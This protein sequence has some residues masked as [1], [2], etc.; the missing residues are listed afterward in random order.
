MMIV[1]IHGME[2]TNYSTT[3]ADK[4]KPRMEL[5]EGNTRVSP[6]VEKRSIIQLFIKI[7]FN[8]AGDKKVIL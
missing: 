1:D 6:Q 2:P 3:S 5:S 8:Q 4:T 7:P